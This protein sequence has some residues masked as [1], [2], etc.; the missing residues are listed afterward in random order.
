MSSSS[1]TARPPRYVIVGSGIAG[2]SAAETL[3]QHVPTAAISMISEEAHDFYS[4][5]GLAYL[6]RG[7]IPE[8]QLFV[9]SRE[10]VRAL[11]VQRLSARVE[12]FLPDEQCVVLAGGRRVAYDR[13]LLALGATAVPPS[14]P[15]GELAGV[16]ELDSLDDAR[17]ILKLAGR[18][19]TAVVVGGG[20]TALELVEGLLARRL[21]ALWHVI[22]IPLG[23]VLFTLAF[24]HIGAALYYATFLK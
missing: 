21:L 7:D 22:H 20:I 18:G 19:K 2:L 12:Q 6:L 14:F 5:P 16:V 10:E 9:R 11:G 15:G 13:L 23:A 3:R 4:R 8:K 17:H 1:A 24:V